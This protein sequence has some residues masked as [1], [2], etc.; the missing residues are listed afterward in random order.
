M[1]RIP[2][3]RQPRMPTG[4]Q[5]SPAHAQPAAPVSGGMDISAQ[6]A[7]D[8]LYKLR[9]E[10]AEVQAIYTGSRGVCSVLRGIVRPPIEDGLWAIVSQ[11]ET[12]GSAL[13]FDLRSATVRRFGD[14]SAVSLASAFPFRIRFVSALSFGF[15]NGSTLSL[16]EI[17]PTDVSRLV[18]S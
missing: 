2:F 1:L 11:Q 10:S 7:V 12:V 14:E 6:E 3:H 4:T 9:E 13:S 18:R 8:L 5:V 15:D 17:A 16:F